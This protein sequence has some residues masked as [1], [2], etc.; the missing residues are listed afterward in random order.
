MSSFGERPDAALA[1]SEARFRAT[2]EQAAVGLAHVAP[3]G[4]W[5]RAN[6]KLCEIVGYSPEELLQRT[7]QDITHPDDL[8]TDLGQVQQVL[9]GQIPTYSREKRYLH[10]DGAIVWV[11]LTVSLVRRQDQSP[12]YFVSVVEDITARK[13]A[14]DRLRETQ[15]ALTTGLSAADDSRHLLLAVLDRVSDGFV[16]L[17]NDWRYTY[18]NQKAAEMLQRQK[19]EDLIGRHIWTEYP[20]GVGQPFHQAYIKA[21][22]TQQPV[23]L[24]Q[25][26]EPWDRWFE[27]RI[28]PSADGLTIYFSEVT[29]RKRAEAAIRQAEERL[30]LAATAG[31]V[32]LW[33]WDLGTNH[34][35]FSP[36]WKRQIGYQDHEIADDFEEWRTRVH[37]EDLDRT[38]EAIN[39]HLAHPRPEYEV[40]FRFRHKNGSYRWIMARGE[41][42]SDAT[43]HPVRMLGCHLDLTER[44][45]AEMQTANERAV[46]EALA[47]GDPLP[48]LLTR[49]VLSYQQMFP[50]T[51]AS[52]LLLDADGRHVRHGAAP[53]LPEAYW[54]AIDGAEIGEAAGS[55]GTAAYTRRTIVVSDIATD[56]LWRD[57][58]DLALAHGLRAC[59]SVPVMSSEDRVLGTFAL[60]YR[61]PRAPEPSEL[62]AVE[63]G[64]R[65]ASVAIERHQLFQALRESEQRLRNLFEQAADGIFL[66]RPDHRYV[67]ANPE[68]LKMLGYSHDELLGLR[69]P[70]VL[71][72]H[73]RRRLDTEVPVMMAGTPHSAE[74]VH[75]RK[76]GT[77]FPA[78]V[79]ARPLAG[80]E[81]FA[82]VR[83]ITERRR[84]EGAL[85]E[86]EQQLRLYAEHA[87]AAI[88]MFDR[89]MRYLVVSRR[90]MEDYGLA[91]QPIIGH[92][93][94]EVFPEIPERWIDVHR[95]C[96]AGATEKCEEDAF[97]RTDGT[98]QWI[99]WEARPWQRAGG[100]I[101]G[102]VIF[103]ED[104]T[105]RKRVEQEI[106]Q[107]NAELEQRVADRTA[108]LHARTRE[109]ETFAYSV[110]HDLKAPLRGIDGYSRLLLEDHA[111]QVDEEGRSFLHNIRQAST[112]MSRLID[113]LLAY[114]RLERRPLQAMQVDLPALAQS[115]LAD[116]ADELRARGVL[117]SMEVPAM[118][119]SADRQGLALALRNL[120]DNALKFTTDVGQPRIEIGGQAGEKGCLL[121]VRDNGIGFEMRFHDR[122]FE[123]FQRLQRSEHYP[124]TGIGLAMVR[125]AME[126]M[127]GRVWAESEPGQGAT[128]F[129]EIPR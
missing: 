112:Q 41:L 6:Q 26:Y 118:A 123:V 111:G 102:I 89:E 90:W 20:E 5:L 12:D 100:E 83:D 17:D 38:L 114:S 62:A 49:L 98:T 25:H 44:K 65:L 11:N 67:D 70:D 92:S 18:V 52:V 13:L 61:E 120:I 79:S 71:A 27:N 66:L 95:R 42:I 107:L 108:E 40:E 104:I 72:E 53:S 28:Y 115:L 124:G 80:Q 35:H 58:R 45:H 103:T 33:D 19:P 117:A 59:W 122:I 48:E 55:C 9:S 101:G 113:D 10:R 7:F 91:E 21:R 93:H 68:G 74:W 96:L 94:Y 76:D 105:E 125:K 116:R 51:L 106:R 16:A 34:V 73:E 126:R 77:T 57:Y 127:G 99:R 119:V 85:H 1:E 8:D 2:F 110:S 24:E 81:Y 32:G 109:L 75:L 128:F 39:D 97:I 54:R 84:A 30:R 15:L 87:P 37:P 14:E 46:L 86:R 31:K 50:G 29:E 64:G 43:G 22:E 56:P 60:Y 63:R 69:L 36:E 78:E 82:I 129:I 47:K 3:D 88:A 121:W 4:R 23:L